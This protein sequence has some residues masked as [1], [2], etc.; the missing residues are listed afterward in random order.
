M[1]SLCARGYSCALILR[2]S[3]T[4]ADFSLVRKRI[5]KEPLV[6][7]GIKNSKKIN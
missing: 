7:K 6:P 4:G 1:A 5:A 3:S 2:A